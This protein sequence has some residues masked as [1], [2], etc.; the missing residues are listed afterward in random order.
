ML[1]SNS[2]AIYLKRKSRQKLKIQRPTKKVET[3]KQLRKIACKERKNLGKNRI[4][5]PKSNR[6][7]PINR[8]S[9]NKMYHKQTYSHKLSQQT[10]K[11][12]KTRRNFFLI[13]QTDLDRIA[14]RNHQHLTQTTR[15]HIQIIKMKQKEFINNKSDE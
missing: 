4:S 5:A 2:F 9:P 3:F 8:E 7:R 10:N 12:W 15:R 6:V 13:N 1:K 11:K 14:S